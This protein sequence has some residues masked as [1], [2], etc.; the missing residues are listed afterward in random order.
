MEKVE[1]L[2]RWIKENFEWSAIAT[3]GHYDDRCYDKLKKVG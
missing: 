3:Y 1:R 2:F